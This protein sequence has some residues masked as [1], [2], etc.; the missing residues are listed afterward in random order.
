MATE[1]APVLRVVGADRHR[2]EMRVAEVKGKLRRGESFVA[3]MERPCLA[4]T[5]A[6]AP[7]VRG[8]CVAR[9][10]RAIVRGL[11]GQPNAFRYLLD[12]S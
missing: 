1:R 8:M 5:C 7:L 3:G 2:S 9:S 12:H 11:R 6:C 4:D 10:D